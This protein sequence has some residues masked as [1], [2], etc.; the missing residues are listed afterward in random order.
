MKF[1]RYYVPTGNV[2]SRWWGDAWLTWEKGYAMLPIPF[3]F[4]VRAALWF[5]W[6]IAVR[7]LRHGYVKQLR[8][9][10][11]KLEH[12]LREQGVKI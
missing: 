8:F 10:V 5:Y 4:I 11:M 9:R 6:G 7:W 3:N 2:P 12:M 1:I